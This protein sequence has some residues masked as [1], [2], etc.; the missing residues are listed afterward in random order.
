[1]LLPVYADLWATTS[2]EPAATPE[3]ALF[4]HG[5]QVH[6]D[7]EIVWRADIDLDDVDA[8]NISLD[9]CPPSSL[10][11]L[12]VPVWVAQR[13]L[14][15]KDDAP[16]A[17]VT[18]RAPEEEEVGRESSCLRYDR[19]RAEGERWTKIESDAV[20]PGDRIVLPCRS[21]GCDEWGWNPRS[22]DEVD[23]L[24]AEAHYLQRLKG[25]L[26]LTRATLMNTLRRKQRDDEADGVWDVISSALPAD[27]EDV[28]A[29]EV[30]DVIE[31]LL[32]SDPPLPKTWQA[33]IDGRDDRR[34]IKNRRP[35]IVPLGGMDWSKGCIIY[36][37]KALDSGLLDEET[38]DEPDG[39]EAV[40]ERNDSS[41]IGEA[42][43]LANHLVH[44]ETKARAFAVGAGLDARV[45]ELVALSARLHDLGKADPRF[46]ADIHG[47]SA[48]FRLGLTEFQFDELL[49]KST[50]GEGLGG[51]V[52][53]VP[54]NFRHEA[55][56]VALAEKHPSVSELDND[57][58]DLVLWLIGTHHG[59]G[60]PFFPPMIDDAA[61]T[62]VTIPDGIVG[63]VLH[64]QAGDLP[65]RLDQGWFERVDRLV[66]RFG[67]WEL[68]RLEAILRLADHAASRAEMDGSASALETT[69]HTEAVS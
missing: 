4:L 32:T 8:T 9:L 47:A 26:R 59:F 63:T 69:K 62:E 3:P 46:Q 10:E 5:P 13:W 41:R 15:A 52:R 6:R 38:E 51:G 49:A 48:L 68:A 42:V 11:A 44:V 7:V 31:A 66:R 57:D 18:E 55:L 1:V 40:T 12:S 39:T 29:P 24:G 36:A 25:A 60:R 2:P 58:R 21:G 43:Q 20:K 61:N 64:A 27:P 54:N 30:R 45:V 53:A 37:D 65:L 56:S 16:F 23:D 35:N 50:R 22:K 33:L 14:G 28:S 19:D 34:G 67:P 17:D